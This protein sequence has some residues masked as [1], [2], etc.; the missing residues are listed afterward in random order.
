MHAQYINVPQIKVIRLSSC[1]RL[2][3]LVHFQD[4]ASLLQLAEK[5]VDDDHKVEVESWN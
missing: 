3:F 1:Y 4:L 2:G 5:A